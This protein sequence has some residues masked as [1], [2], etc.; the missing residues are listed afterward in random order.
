MVRK[1]LLQGDTLPMNIISLYYKQIKKY[2][3]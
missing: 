1:K 2:V 3:W